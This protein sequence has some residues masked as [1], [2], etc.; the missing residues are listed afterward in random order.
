MRRVVAG[1][2]VLFVLT[3]IGMLTIGKEN[4]FGFA[5]FLVNCATIL[6]LGILGVRALIDRRR[7]A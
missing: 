6:G 2:A 7:A 1:L 3:V 4:N 5:C